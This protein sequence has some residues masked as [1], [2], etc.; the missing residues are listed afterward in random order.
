MFNGHVHG[1]ISQPTFTQYYI[2]HISS[3]IVVDF[4]TGLC[5][6]EFKLLSSV[7]TSRNASL[8]NR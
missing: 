7:M 8:Y 3:E 2:L 4:R 6:R 5:M 1:L